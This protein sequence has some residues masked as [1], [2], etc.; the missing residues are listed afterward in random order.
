ME[1]V[2]TL[3]FDPL[4]KANARQ[5]REIGRRIMRAIDP[6]NPCLSDR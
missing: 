1:A 2:R 6:D 3:I 4:T 5:L